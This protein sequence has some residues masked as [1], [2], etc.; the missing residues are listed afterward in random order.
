VTGVGKSLADARTQ[1]YQTISTID[2]DKSFYRSD[3]ALKAS[4]GK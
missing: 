2:L 1:A 3:I 4:E